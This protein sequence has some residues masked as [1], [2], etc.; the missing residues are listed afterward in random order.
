MDNVPNKIGDVG[1]EVLTA[2]VINIVIWDTALCSLYVNRRFGRKYHVHIQDRK[3][4]AQETS[5]QQ[6]T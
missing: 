5:V 3:S 4:T 1:F 2:V 6:V